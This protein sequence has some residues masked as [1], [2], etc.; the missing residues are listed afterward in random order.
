MEEATGTFFFI[1]MLMPKN[2]KDKRGRTWEWTFPDGRVVLVCERKAGSKSSH[3]HRGEDPSKNPE[4][5]LIARGSV[6]ITF[7]I[8]DE[9]STRILRSGDSV[10]IGPGVLHRT[11]VLE[12]AIILEYRITR[13]D[14]EH[15]DTE[16]AEF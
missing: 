5:L 8:N 3:V 16:N 2:P 11:E 7:K 13:F 14:P 15:P 10:E 4:R 12:D 6:E 1:D 9:V